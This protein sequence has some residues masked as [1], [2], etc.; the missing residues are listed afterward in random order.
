MY[1]REHCDRK[2]EIDEL[3][4]CVAELQKP[5]AER[6]QWPADTKWR[7]SPLEWCGVA[8]FFSKIACFFPCMSGVLFFNVS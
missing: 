3:L 6:R 8:W 7:L 4:E 1:M 5:A 2:A